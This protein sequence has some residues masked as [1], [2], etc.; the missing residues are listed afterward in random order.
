ME[1]FIIL[2]SLLE[3]FRIVVC[4]GE[5]INDLIVIA[6]T[7]NAF[8]LHSIMIHCCSRRFSCKKREVV[9]PATAEEISTNWSSKW[10][11]GWD[12]TLFSKP[13]CVRICHRHVS[14]EHDTSKASWINPSFHYLFPSTPAGV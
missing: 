3:F 8:L 5:F 6:A 11:T 4:D 10:N 13:S 14:D 7:L 2:V 1:K 9:L 12:T